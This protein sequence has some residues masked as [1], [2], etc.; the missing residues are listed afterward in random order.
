M[1]PAA[2]CADGRECWGGGDAAS[3]AD[4]AAAEGV[5]GDGGEVA[6]GAASRLAGVEYE[7]EQARSF[8]YT[9]REL[10]GYNLSE[11]LLY[12]LVLLLVGAYL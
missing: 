6:V 12:A 3:A 1:T 11:A 10:E 9:A 4:A 5:E 8:H 2:C 7:F